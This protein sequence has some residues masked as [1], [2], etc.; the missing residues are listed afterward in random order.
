MTRDDVIRMAREAG[1]AGGGCEALFRLVALVEAAKEAEHQ[2][3]P[4]SHW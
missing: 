3:G 4:P 1:F 2:H